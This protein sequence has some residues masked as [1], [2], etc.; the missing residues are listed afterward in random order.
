MTSK[1]GQAPASGGSVAT[2][3][4]ALCGAATLAVLVT[5]ARLP[6]ADLYHTSVDGLAGG[7]GRALVYLNF[8]IALAAIG[9]VLVIWPGLAGR[10]RIAGLAAISLCAVTVVSVDQDDLDARWLNVLPAAGV[11]LALALSLRAPARAAQRL[12]GDPLRVV[13]AVLLAVLAV[14]WLYAMTGFYAPGPIMADELSR[15]TAPT[16]D[17]ETLP[18]VHL[19]SHH[20]FDGVLLALS[21]LWLSRARPLTWLA[22]FVLAL[23]LAYGIANAVQDEWF[24]QVVKRG[25]TE[26]SLPGMILPKLSLGW[27]GIVVGAVLVWSLWFRA[28]PAQ[29]R[30]RRSAWKSSSHS[31]IGT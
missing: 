4:W 26:H 6:P 15:S 28:E 24:E 2:A 22:S 17:E 3:V 23:M 12:R 1:R 9:I 7:L 21:A 20:G 18:A 14:P 30:G 31:D 19:G 16:S 29:P 27:L 5:Y 13:L 11:A 10:E 25:W 8:P